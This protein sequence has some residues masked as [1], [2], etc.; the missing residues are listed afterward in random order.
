M[1]QT[2]AISKLED[3]LLIPVG[4]ENVLPALVAL[5]GT[6]DFQEYLQKVADA[7]YRTAAEVAR[8]V[9]ACERKLALEAAKQK[10]LNPFAPA[11]GSAARQHTR[12]QNNEA[13]QKFTNK[14][15][16]SDRSDLVRKCGLCGCAL[17]HRVVDK[18]TTTGV[19][20]TIIL[21]LFCIPLIFIPILFCREKKDEYYCSHCRR[22][23]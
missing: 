6:S 16:S 13:F 12:A 9:D 21:L 23:Y 17:E 1:T 8:E 3:W 18:M 2:E 19:V 4:I 7:D 22:I 15:V 5:K 11:G 20:W 10:P 14:H